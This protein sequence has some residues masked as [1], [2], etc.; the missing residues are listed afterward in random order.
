M[1]NDLAMA[2][3]AAFCM[4]FTEAQ[5]V[6]LQKN[7]GLFINQPSPDAA[8]SPHMFG[9][10][11][12]RFSGSY[13]GLNCPVLLDLP[14]PVTLIMTNNLVTDAVFSQMPVFTP[15]PGDP[16]LISW[17]EYPA[18]TP[19][20][21]APPVVPPTA[22]PTN[23]PTAVPTST[24]MPSPTQNMN[25]NNVDPAPGTK[26]IEIIA[27]SAAGLIALASIV[28][29]LCYKKTNDME[30]KKVAYNAYNHSS[31]IKYQSLSEPE[32]VVSKVQ[33]K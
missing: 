26:V 20:P 17:D 11:A 12:N 13:N 2:D 28:Y 30:V 16:Y 22:A 5:V 8:I 29:C 14:N 19:V 32:I 21:T 24:M 25:I 3:T 10:L 27:I 15:I 23:I 4:H 9:F 33:R 31:E 18:F 7:K 1:V 6:R